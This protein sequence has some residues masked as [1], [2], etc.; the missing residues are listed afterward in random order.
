MTVRG[1]FLFPEVNGS[2][3]DVF[4]SILRRDR[5]L[6]VFRQSEVS[7]VRVVSDLHLARLTKCGGEDGPRRRDYLGG[8]VVSG[9]LFRRWAWLCGLSTGMREGGGTSGFSTGGVL[10]RGS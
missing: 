6:H 9:C 1:D 2:R 4:F 7:Y 3:L 8:P 5:V 10:Q